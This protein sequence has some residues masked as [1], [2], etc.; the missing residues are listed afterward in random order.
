[1]LTDIFEDIFDKIINRI[2][3][4]IK[5]L[6]DYSETCEIK[7]YYIPRDKISTDDVYKILEEF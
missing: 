2:N 7:S 1:L 3:D 5:M 4:R 6:T